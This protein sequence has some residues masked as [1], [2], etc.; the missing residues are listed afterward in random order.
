MSRY[1]PGFRAESRPG[2]LERSAPEGLASAIATKR[3]RTT[4]VTETAKLLL[5]GGLAG[6]VSK[7]ATAPLARLTILYQVA[8]SVGTY[9]CAQLNIFHICHMCSQLMLS[10]LLLLL[11]RSR[12]CKA[13][14][15]TFTRPRC[16]KQSTRSFSEKVCVPCGRGMES[17]C[18][19]DCH[20]LLSISGHMSNSQSSGISA[21]QKLTSPRTLCC[22]GLQL[23]AQLACWLAPWYAQAVVATE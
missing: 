3:Q 14:L 8:M 6:A 11:H 19:T 7:S 2:A 17:P 16:S 12:G 9:D 4:E 5:A 18:C 10:F 20:T 15:G 22:G 21:S 13:Q 23:E 1:S